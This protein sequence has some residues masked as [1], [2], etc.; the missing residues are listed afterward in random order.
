M[1][2]KKNYIANREDLLIITGNHGGYYAGRCAV[3][4]AIGWIE[5]LKHDK[6][7]PVGTECKLLLVREI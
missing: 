5:D 6:N 1:A 2:N 4:G 3:C 7:C